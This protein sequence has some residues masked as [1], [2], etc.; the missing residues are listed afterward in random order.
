MGRNLVIC[1]DG[2]GNIWGS[3]SDT[4]VVKLARILLK[5]N[6]QILYY[7]PGVGTSNSY[8][9]IGRISQIK[10]RVNELLG[11]AR[12]GGIYENIGQAYGFLVEHYQPGDRVFLFGFSRGAFTAR[13]VGG[14]VNLFGIVRRGAETMIPTLTRIYFQPIEG[15]GGTGKTRKEYGDDIRAVFAP[16]GH[17][18]RIHFLGVW[19]TV[20]TVGGLPGSKKNIT[21]SGTI[22]GKNYDHVRHAVASS[23][24]RFAYAPRLFTDDNFDHGTTSLQQLWF[25]GAHSDI[26]GSYDED[27]LSNCSLKW[28]V[29]EAVAKG[30]QCDSSMAAGIRPDPLGLAH[31]QVFLQPLWTLTGLRTRL[32]PSGAIKHKSF[33][34]REETAVAGK[35]LKSQW[36]T[37]G[38]NPLAIGSVS[39]AIMMFVVV[40]FL[41]GWACLNSC[42]PEFNMAVLQSFLSPFGNTDVFDT[43]DSFRMTIRYAADYFFIITYTLAIC[44]ILIYARRALADRSGN[45]KL[46]SFAH[47]GS[48][49]P[50]WTLISSDILENGVTIYLLNQEAGARASH[51]GLTMF[52][53]AFTTIK[54]LS[55]ATLFCFSVWLCGY[56]LSKAPR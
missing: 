51:V 53:T 5:S 43:I 17:D 9:A 21:S 56:C 35:P 25:A 13:C 1:C 4:N 32:I 29:E 42:A 14:M 46:H 44:W 3:N 37:F 30:L 47:W 11:L 8:P 16:G 12:G 36:K 6:T 28:M 55:L 34:L 22:L 18:A 15:V 26:G 31:D 19:D 24:Y 27:G 2:T 39:A 10:S 52:L 20:S 33:I 23:E 7:D 54:L 38:S 49:I 45:A 50:L 40:D 48:V 41:G